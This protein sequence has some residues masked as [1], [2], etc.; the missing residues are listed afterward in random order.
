V[1]ISIRPEANGI[2]VVG[3]NVIVA[4]LSKKLEA[5]VELVVIDASSITPKITSYASAKMMGV[6]V[7][8]IFN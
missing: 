7:S 2:A 4:T 3:I 5:V 6:D 8:D 1:S